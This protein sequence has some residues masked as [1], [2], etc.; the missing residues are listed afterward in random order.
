MSD[1]TKLE[2]DL[3]RIKR[4]RQK[5][6]GQG[7]IIKDL[8]LIILIIAMLTGWFLLVVEHVNHNATKSQ[9]TAITAKYEE[10]KSRADNTTKEHTPA[11]RSH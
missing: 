8:P 10:L 7:K 3:E 1:K 11:K 6:P 4:P 5:E 9:L 2:L